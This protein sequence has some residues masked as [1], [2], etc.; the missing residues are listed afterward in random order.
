MIDP[1]E[2]AL[3]PLAVIL[4]LILVA[5]A[6]V[7]VAPVTELPDIISTPFTL[8]LVTCV[9]EELVTTVIV[10]VSVV[11]ILRLVKK[12]PT[13]LIGAMADVEA[14]LELPHSV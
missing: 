11:A 1:D 3:K 4:V 7:E 9:L 14:P 10:V 13:P 2:F 8:I 5:K 6:L 12:P